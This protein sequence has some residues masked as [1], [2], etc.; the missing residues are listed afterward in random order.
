[1]RKKLEEKKI[2]KKNWKACHK[3]DD[4]NNNMYVLYKYFL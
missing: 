2:M 1:M 3:G 4:Y